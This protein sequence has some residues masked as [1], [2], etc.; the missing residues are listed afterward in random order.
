MYRCQ[1]GDSFQ[2]TVEIPEFQIKLNDSTG[3]GTDSIQQWTYCCSF[4]LKLSVA[5]S[6]CKIYKWT[7]W[8]LFCWPINITHTVIIIIRIFV[9]SSILMKW[10]LTMMMKVGWWSTCSSWGIQCVLATPST[11]GLPRPGSS[12]CNKVY[13]HI[14]FSSNALSQGLYSPY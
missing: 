10:I 6:R 8:Q 5:I 9:I 7:T 2:V 4:K 1:N 11:L 3:K 14:I 13:F 12:S